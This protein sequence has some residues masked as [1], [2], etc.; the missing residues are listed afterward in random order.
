MVALPDYM[1]KRLLAILC[2]GLIGGFSALFLVEYLLHEGPIHLDFFGI[3]SW[4]RF[5]I[6]RPPAQIY[7]HHEQYAFLLA[8]DP[9]FRAPMPFP[10]PPTYLLLIK[11]LGYL[12][13]PVAQL[14][15]S[16]ATLL[17]FLAAVRLW[18]RR[19]P[20]TALTLLAPASAINLL[21]GQNGFLTAALVL[22]G[23]GLLRF[24][25]VLG[26]IL[27][28]L[29]TYKLQF[30]LLVAVALAAAGL[31]KSAFAAG[32]TV[33][34]TVGASML[35]FGI[36]P[37][38]AWFGAMPEF[39]RFLDGQRARLLG[40]M[41]TALAGALGLGAGDRL[42]GVVQTT[43]TAAAAAS[44]WIAFRRDGPDRLAVAALAVAVILATPYA[45]LYDLP[46]VAAGV[47]LFGA[48][49]WPTLTSK[50]VLL[51]AGALLLPA[52][53]L[54][55]LVPPAVSV[56]ATGCVLALMLVRARPRA[57][58]APTALRGLRAE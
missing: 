33:L 30:G 56:V 51:L 10:Y 23:F 15:W 42:A 38:L 31:W 55:D 26:G 1:L 50:E 22:G 21:Y 32:V 14:V 58:A 54:L 20:V 3:W 25:P 17:A 46:L 47:I 35:V 12:S 57:A 7:S 43:A 45:F 6:E 53:M 4:A 39:V 24:Q 37:W 36:E 11:P 29:L 44:I 18:D 49:R 5:A 40:M 28:G 34:G 9:G 52:G 41:P 8:L 19:L 2:F 27:L 13:Y 16:G 48:D